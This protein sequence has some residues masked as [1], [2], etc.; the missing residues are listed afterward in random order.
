MDVDKRLWFP[1]GIL[2]LA[3]LACSIPGNISSGDQIRTQIALTQAAHPGSSPTI[4][5]IL[6][7]FTQTITTEPIHILTPSAVPTKTETPAPTLTETLAENH[8][9]ADCNIATFIKD[10]SVPDGTKFSAGESFVKTWRLK[11]IGSCT[12]TTAYAVVFVSGEQMGGPEDL[13]FTQN[14]A[15]GDTVD[16]SINLTAPNATGDYRGNWKI[17]SSDGVV[18]GLT[19]GKAFYVEITVKP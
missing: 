18:F 8:S 2:I 11:N 6:A 4:Q 19:T 17:R 7:D 15:P 12:W 14:V 9:A 16:V 1:A 5:E 3:I 10:V 13:N